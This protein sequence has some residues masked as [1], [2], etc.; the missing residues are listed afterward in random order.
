MKQQYRADAIATAPLPSEAP[1]VGNPT[2]GDPANNVLATAF[3]AYEAYS[4]FSELEAVIIAGGLTPDVSTLTQVRDAIG[5]LI[6][7]GQGLD[8]A[9]G[10]ARYLRQAENLADLNSVVNARNNLSVYSQAQV[11]NALAALQAT[12][13]GGAAN[14]RDTL[15]ELYSVLN[16][17]IA[18]RLTQAEGDARY[19]RLPVELFYSAAGLALT[20]AEAGTEVAVPD[21]SAYR[22]IELMFTGSAGG[23]GS[24]KIPQAVMPSSGD[25]EVGLETYVDL[26]LQ[27]R[28]WAPTAQELRF[29]QPLQP[30]FT[31]WLHAVLGW[32]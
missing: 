23:S 21:M 18:L 25:A 9:T 15:Q 13:E 6:A 27:V 16:A 26:D 24:V 4:L 3:G 7:A 12:I 19:S 11:D 29:R 17:A 32:R 30:A 14:S 22:Y 8:T 28:Y 5:A 1:S 2:N 31:T 10:D 20:Q